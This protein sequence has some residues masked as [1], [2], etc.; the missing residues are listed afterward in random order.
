MLAFGYAGDL[1]SIEFH[2]KVKMSEML[3]LMSTSQ[4]INPELI[5]ATKKIVPGEEGSFEMLSI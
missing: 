1:S 5:E 4:I 3:T 2:F